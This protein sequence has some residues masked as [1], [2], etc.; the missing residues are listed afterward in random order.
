MVR[1]INITARHKKTNEWVNMQYYSI[2]QARFYNKH[3]YDFRCIGYVNDNNNK[4]KLKQTKL[5]QFV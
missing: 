4:S 1:L 2:N 5:N 3:Y